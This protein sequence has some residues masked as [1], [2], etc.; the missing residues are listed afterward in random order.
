ML[1][2]RFRAAMRR[3]VGSDHGPIGIA[4]SG[5]ADS[6]ALLFLAH[7]AC[8]GQIHAAT[9]DHGLRAEAQA[10]ARFVASVC[11]GL[12]VPH[13]TLTIPAAAA[14]RL[15]AGGNLQAT[16][17]AWRF[18]LLCAWCRDNGLAW[19]ATAHHADDQAETLLMRL[20]RG[21]GLAGLSGVRARREGSPA[22]IRPLLGFTKAELVG[23]CAAAGIT[24]VA[25]PSNE[26]PR[27]DRTHVRIL[28]GS[29]QWLDP[30]RL[31]AAAHHLAESEVALAWAADRLMEERRRADTE[32][33]F[34]YDLSGLPAELLRRIAARAI[35]HV[36]AIATLDPNRPPPRGPELQRLIETVASGQAATLG[37][38]RVHRRGDLWIFAAAPP[39]RSH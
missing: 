24:P 5:G 21:A 6:L 10:E 2:E 35:A 22:I 12:S 34:G 14:D 36:D 20:A 18:R 4:V 19:L 33:A 32:S 13:A 31:A 15:R 8:P 26:D 11:E 17:R 30:L 3:L 27:F 9:V 23:F 25:D 39:R 37:H 38:T 29:T 28:L 16:A 1:V 7:A